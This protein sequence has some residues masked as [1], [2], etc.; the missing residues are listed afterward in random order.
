MLDALVELEVVGQFH[1]LAIDA[2]ADVA[3]L[4]HVGEEVFELPLLSADDRREHEES[5]AFGKGEDAADDLF[6]RLSRDRPRA[7]RT[8]ADAQASVEHAKVIRDFRNGADRGAR[9]APGRLLLN[10][11]GG[12]QAADEV[13]VRL[14]ELPEELPGVTRQRL[15]VAALTFGINRVEGER[16]FARP[17]DAG[18][19]DEFVAREFEI[20][21]AE[22]VFARAADHD[23]LR[24]H[25]K[26]QAS[27]EVSQPP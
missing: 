4:N 22:V 10:A 6:A 26:S 15:D 23:R 14:R 12:G 8:V 24:I 27:T 19:H 1:E 17:T 16:A 5:R 7:F 11:D 21:V 3:A 18:E 9:I 20:D 13:D 25:A 2:G